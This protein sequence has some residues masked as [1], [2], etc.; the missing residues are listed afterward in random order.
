M[1]AVA[2]R[3]ARERALDRPPI[4]AS[5]RPWLALLL[6]ALRLWRTRIGLALVA[7]CWC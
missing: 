7:G 1:S 2:A 5:R 6:R 4:A 3:P